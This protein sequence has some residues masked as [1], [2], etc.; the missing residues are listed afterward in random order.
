MP[1]FD[2]SAETLEARFEK[3]RAFLDD[4]GLG[5]LFAYSPPH[6]HL[7]GQTGHVSYLSGWA[8]HDRFVDSAVVVPVSGRPSLLVGA[9]AEVVFPLI[10]HVSPLEDVRL[11]QSAEHH[12]FDLVQPGSVPP[13]NSHLSF[14]AET[15]AILEESGNSRKDVGVVGLNNMPLPIYE[16]LSKELGGRLRRVDDIVAELRSV[17]SPEEIELMKHA[18]RLNDLGFETMLKVARPGV[19]GIEI[20]AEME[21]VM[22]REG[23]DHAKFWIASGPAPD[24]NNLRFEI[25]PHH[26]V[27]EEGDLMAACSYVVYKGYW[28]H[29]QRAGSFMRPVQELEDLC[30]KARGSADA[31]LSHMKPGVPIARVAR[32]M[33]EKMAE[34]GIHKEA[35]GRVGHAIGLDYGE[36]PVPTENNETLLQPGMTF[37]LHAGYPLPD[38]RKLGVPL[39]DMVRVTPGGFEFLT[40]FTREPFLA[41]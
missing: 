26:R 11:V 21:R 39:G 5:A 38:P 31:G 18:A 35:G 19:Q 15:L 36:L 33:R 25:K 16:P 41:G 6:E 22:R 17:K 29:A 28:C 3:I 32:A 27:L 37:A 7:W 1:S 20:V 40:K 12:V 4:R 2:I 8:N 13:T 14:A 30:A 23:A 34:Y 10:A 24:W 9:A